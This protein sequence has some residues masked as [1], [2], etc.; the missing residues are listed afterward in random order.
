MQIPFRGSGV[1][2][3]SDK[4]YKCALY[5]SETCGGIVLQIR[6]RPNHGLGDY[7]ELPLE[8]DELCGELDS[9]YEFT[10]IDLERGE[11]SNDISS[12]MTVY[13]YYAEYLLS[14]IKNDSFEKQTFSNVSF[15][16]ANIVEWGEESVYYIGESHELKAKEKPVYKTLYQDDNSLIRYRVVGDYLPCVNMEL[17]RENIELRQQGI[18]E[19]EFKTEHDFKDFV[20]TF[21][22][23]KSLFEIALLGK[24]RVEEMYGFSNKTKDNYGD[25]SFERQIDIYGRR[26]TKKGDAGG[27]AE[28]PMRLRKITLSNLIDNSSFDVYMKKHEQLQPILDLYI[29]QFYLRGGATRVFLNIVQALETYHSR[30]VTNDMKVFKK[31]IDSLM[32]GLSATNADYIKSALLANSKKFITLESRLA[33]LL[34]AEGKI[35]FD[36]GD[37]KHEDFPSVIAH[38]RNYYIHYDE[39]IRKNYEVFTSAEL[40]IYVRVLFQILEYY[41][42]S[43]LGFSVENRSKMI[44][45]RWGGVSRD[46]EILKTSRN[47]QAQLKTQIK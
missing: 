30:F 18:I 46:L 36:T 7:L 16:L 41:I 20:N 5:Y 34:Y 9:G 27:F 21:D 39:E 37:V 19:I 24:V 31:R 15:V 3:F 45:D 2:Y 38:T 40:S 43:E 6:H 44:H 12:G 42:L 33:D 4:V 8:I 29:E 25:K 11:M 14:G 1:V 47:K 22:K 13:T 10:L 17:L 35:H 28:R 26:I 23:L 32:Q